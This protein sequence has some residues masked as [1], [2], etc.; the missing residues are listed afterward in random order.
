VLVLA[1]A[2]FMAVGG[3]TSW[4]QYY[5]NGFKVGPNCGTPDAPLANNWIDAADIQPAKDASV[6]GCWWTV[7]ND[8]KLERLIVHA[9]RQNLTLKQAGMRILQARAQYGVA[10]GNIFPQSQVATGSFSRNGMAVDPSQ[11]I[12][13]SRFTDRWNSSFSLAWELD[14]WG[15]F[16]RAIA[17]A[18]DNLDASVA[19]YQG[20]LVTLLGDVA[21]NYVNVRTA[22]E[23]IKLLKANVELQQG[24]YD[25]IDKRFT[26]GWKT[27]ELDLD[28]A[29]SNLRQ[30]Q[31]SIPQ[32][33][34]SL[35][36]AENRLCILMGMP[37]EDLRE[38]L[39]DGPIPTS[40]VEVAAGIPADLLRNRPDVRR[41]ESL[42]AAQ[43]EQI[44]IAT[45][46]LYPAFSLNGSFG[47]SARNFSDLFNTTALNGSVGPSFRWNLL[48]YGRLLNNIRA[49]EAK[50]RELVYA[51]Q[52]TVLNAQEEVENGLITFLR[53]E[54]RSKLL[55]ESVVAAEK[56]VK[57]VVDQYQAGAVDFNRYA[58]IEQN[59]VTQQD[60]AAQAKGQIALGLISVYR[61]LGGGWDIAE[62]SAAS[63][64]PTAPVEE[65]R[66][67]WPEEIPLPEPPARPEN[68]PGQ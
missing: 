12:V 52:N 62:F 29:L 32:L 58:L 13:G 20:V 63:E 54:Q 26:G 38:L 59:L 11:P 50:F 40:P 64:S 67:G 24:I 66:P 31:A 17:A 65:A 61:A 34:I 46:E 15:R 8:P 68:R 56:A 27:T 22:Q 19:D 6:A 9:Y 14:F 57:I 5:R 39:G 37:P 18:A 48:N 36:Q 49:Q 60:L 47:Y 3:C 30:T 1:V 7:F 41:A 51:Y 35:R 43:G 42:A 53:S 33:E 16:R 23:R 2:A 28:Q 44:G 4:S 45:A 10:V 21:T 25:W 55:D